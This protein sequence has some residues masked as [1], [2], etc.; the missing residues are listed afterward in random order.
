[1]KCLTFGFALLAVLPG[2]LEAQTGVGVSVPVVRLSL[3][4][5]SLNVSL[6]RRG[7]ALSATPTAATTAGS[8]TRATA[9]A[10]RVLATGDRYLGTRYRYGGESPGTGFDGSGFVQ[11]VYARHGI[12]LPRTSRE[13]ATAGTRVSGGVAGLR[14]GDL[15][16]FASAGTRVDH[17]AIYAG[18]GRML[19]SSASGRGVGYDDLSSPRG[20]WFMARHVVSRRV[21]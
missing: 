21:L 18:N 5:V 9:S 17:V 15:M 6:D 14:P 7:V 1:M 3:G 4:P 10:S 11:Y 12:E 2:V 20:E 19:H 8:S 16:L 13:Q